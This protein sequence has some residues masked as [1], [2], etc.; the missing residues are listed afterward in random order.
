M[1]ITLHLHLDEGE[2]A[3][4]SLKSEIVIF[5]D[6]YFFFDV[7]K[8]DAEESVEHFKDDTELV[9]DDVEIIERDVFIGV[10]FLKDAR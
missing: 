7:G 2:E 3:F 10:V 6:L 4:M 9:E 5:N 8:G 1:N